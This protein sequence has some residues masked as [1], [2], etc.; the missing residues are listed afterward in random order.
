MSNTNANNNDDEF[1]NALQQRAD[2]IPL[3]E[4]SA[5]TSESGTLFQRVIKELTNSAMRTIV[6][7]RGCGK[8][9]MMRFAWLQC[10]AKPAK[11]F[12]IYVSFNRYFRL[13]PLLSSR[14]GAL[15]QFH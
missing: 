5:E 1:D 7:P 2:Y 11:P 6:G 9:H 15:N 8:T 3:E 10:R 14:P 4:L 12:A 13:E